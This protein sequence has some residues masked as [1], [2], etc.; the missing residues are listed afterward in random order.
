MWLFNGLSLADHLAAPEEAPAKG[1]GGAGEPAVFREMSENEKLVATG[2]Y[3]T[4]RLMD[5]HHRVRAP[6]G[7]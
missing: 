3:T 4:C 5:Y 1:G 6:R 7:R 2:A